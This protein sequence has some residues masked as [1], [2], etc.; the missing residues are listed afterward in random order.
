M[1]DQWNKKLARIIITY[2]YIMV[3]RLKCLEVLTNDVIWQQIMVYMT[4]VYY[5]LIG[6]VKHGIPNNWLIYIIQEFE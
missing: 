2:I 4:T 6:F 3:D 5:I 1:R